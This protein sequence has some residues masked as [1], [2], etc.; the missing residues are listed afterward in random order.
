MFKYASTGDP[1]QIPADTWNI[2]QASAKAWVQNKHNTKFGNAHQYQYHYVRNNTGVDLPAF[3]VVGL[4]GVVTEPAESV[5]EFK[6]HYTI[7]GVV[8]TTDHYDRW[9][10]TQEPIKSGLI[11]HCITIGLTVA[12]VT[13]A[14]D[15]EEYINCEIIPG[16]TE[17]LELLPTG[18]CVVI[19]RETGLGTKW[20]LIRIDSTN[21]L[22]IAET[23]EPCS[24][25]CIFGEKVQNLIVD[26]NGLSAK[27]M[28][29]CDVPD[30][31]MLKWKGLEVAAD[32]C[33]SGGLGLPSYVHELNFKAPLEVSAS[34]DENC[35]GAGTVSL[36][37]DFITAKENSCIT[38][39]QSDCKY[40]IDLD[41]KVQGGTCIEVTGE[42]CTKTI[43]NTMDIQGGTCI[44]VSGEGCT[45]TI[46]NTM[47]I[48]AG[49]C[50]SVTGG[51]E[52]ACQKTIANT[53]RVTGGN[54]IVVSKSGC[55]YSV[56]LDL[57]NSTKTTFRVLCDIDIE[58]T[59]VT[60]ECVE[61]SGGWV[62]QTTG[63]VLTLTKYFTD[64][65]L[66]KQVVD[67]SSD[68]P[69]QEEP[70]P[71]AGCLV[72]DP[73]EAYE[74]LIYNPDT[75]TCACIP[76]GTPIPEGYEYCNEP[77]EVPNCATCA[78]CS[79]GET[80]I[81]EIGKNNCDCIPDTDPVP[82]GWFECPAPEPGEG[83]GVQ[84]NGL[85][86]N[87]VP[88]HFSFT[89]LGMPIGSTSY[90]IV[91]E[92]T[93]GSTVTIG[94]SDGAYEMIGEEY[95]GPLKEGYGSP[96]TGECFTFSFTFDGG[97]HQTFTGCCEA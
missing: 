82:A 22:K 58:L 13:V 61:T 78:D 75:E 95:W 88:P 91:V 28:A 60:V 67:L 97:E 90:T 4:D 71:P 94:P 57:D 14:E 86:C 19:W 74:D 80:K 17:Y 43:N 68:C 87:G 66:P 44:S 30:T 50:I 6:Y 59:P 15:F 63:G 65:T 23:R 7:T 11:G 10:I 31:W 79:A 70:D 18:S 73:C 85:T 72:C 54:G 64:I 27:K 41:Y 35:P 3:S 77:V 1:L 62:F 20:A 25:E 96:E 55:T 39:T 16:T 5:D 81:I 89:F 36:P 40:E 42:G 47:E 46:N 8:P 84:F 37:D 83:Y 9:A 49:E 38:V 29:E 45:K 32:A 24:D 69:V 48:I 2:I 56:N 33:G 51:Q 34:G 53:M 92:G 52:N 93:S 21:A 12:K 26:T 76:A